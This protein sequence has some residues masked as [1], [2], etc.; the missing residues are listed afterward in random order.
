[1]SGKRYSGEFK[2]EA[3]KEVVEYGHSVS[4]VATR[5]EIST[6]S[7]YAWIKKSDLGTSASE[8]QPDTEARLGLLQKQMD[9]I[10]KERDILKKALVYFTKRSD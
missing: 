10:T 8:N 5:L 6:H 3:I 4:V 1:M 7:L 9:Q 2:A